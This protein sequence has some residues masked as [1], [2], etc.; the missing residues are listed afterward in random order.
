MLI[1]KLGLGCEGNDMVVKSPYLFLQT[2]LFLWEKLNA[3]QRFCLVL[4]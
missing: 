1:P 3:N 2:S 4:P